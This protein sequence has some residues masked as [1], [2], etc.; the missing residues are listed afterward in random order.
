MET[1]I[2]LDFLVNNP[3]YLVYHLVISLSLI[4]TGALA[5]HHA[6]KSQSEQSAK[7]VFI[8]CLILLG[9]QVAA[10]TFQLIAFST[11]GFNSAFKIIF[12][13]LINVLVLVWLLWIF[14][15]TDRRLLLTGGCI[16]FSSFLVV[17]AAIFV[18]ISN[19]PSAAFL[20][21]LQTTH[22]IWLI[23]S[24]I[25]ITVIIVILMAQK[26]R[27]HLVGAAIFLVLA[28][29]FGLQIILN[30]RDNLETG[31]VRMA[32]MITIP[33]MLILVQR[34]SEK[35]IPV[36]EPFIKNAKEKT[37]SKINIKTELIQ[38]LLDINLIDEIA[39][40][41][42]AIA[43]I[44]SLGAA[45]DIC[46]IVQITE[47]QYKFA[48][49]AGYDLIREV[50][51]EPAQV[52][53]EDLLHTWDAWLE[54]QILIID[55]DDSDTRDAFTLA[56]LINFHR[57][58]SLFAYPLFDEQQVISGGI[59]FLSPYTNKRYGE[60]T[61]TLIESIQ[62]SLGE[63]MFQPSP[64]RALKI[65]LEQTLE[66]ISQL[67]QENEEI[68][69]ELAEKIKIL[70]HQKTSFQELRANFQIE[71]FASIKKI[72]QL[73]QELEK[74]DT[75]GQL[76][77]KYQ[78]RLEQLNTEIR[79]LI[80][81]RDQ[82]KT[83]LMRAN[84]R[85]KDLEM[86]TGQTGPI[87]LSMDTQIVSLDSIAANARLKVNASLQDKQL[88]LKINN[89]DGR[90]MIKTDPELLQTAL[91]GLLINAIL[92]SGQNTDVLLSLALSFET[93]MLIIE[94]TDHGE[95]LTAD[96]QKALFN[97]QKEILPGIGSIPSIREAI[98]AIRVLSG[99]LWLRSKKGQFTTF[100][101]QLP[102]RIID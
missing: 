25:T 94:V 70:S 66:Q 97:T 79:Q 15:E 98:R 29:G 92:A 78:Q 81:Q 63:I 58:G 99:K 65:E 45:A 74:K 72:E 38:Q 102:V 37:D 50:G 75:T 95:G 69:S 55:N 8:G 22:I 23:I 20:I 9:L 71:K 34:F 84:N 76:E 90:Q 77:E 31:V 53:R 96:E 83:L 89:P 68:R 91:G 32:Q 40:K 100:R 56:M 61:I 12:N 33:W 59:L 4:W 5:F 44:L 48:L 43:H 86:Q 28:V 26:P 21:N 49:T 7:Q 73:K 87:R 101:V 35:N 42:Q 52:D 51:L 18:F 6:K 41:H 27:Q 19:I 16:F 57:I 82:L 47:D 39:E 62:A 46:Y 80:K 3:G 85:I 1:L 64:V 11:P 10:F 93:G 36:N 30:Y 60:E 2:Q 88:D 14:I 24:L 54:G 13:D 17:A 67:N